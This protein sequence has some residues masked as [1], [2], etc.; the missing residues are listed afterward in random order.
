[1]AEEDFQK[2]EIQNQRVSK[3][4]K[5]LKAGVILLP[6]NVRVTLLV[7]VS[8][9]NLKA[10]CSSLSWSLSFCSWL[11]FYSCMSV[12]LWIVSFA[13]STKIILTA[14]WIKAIQL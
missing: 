13:S 3:E 9:L 10:Q 8:V 2:E 4:R 14:A 12:Q 1:M 5:I 11:N 7:L 6:M